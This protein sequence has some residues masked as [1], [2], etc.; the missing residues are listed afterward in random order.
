MEGGKG[1]RNNQRKEG[2]KEYRNQKNKGM[3][4]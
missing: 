3:Q 4:E 2:R 1:G